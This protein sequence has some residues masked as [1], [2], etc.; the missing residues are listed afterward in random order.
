MIR[1]ALIHAVRAAMAPVEE[2]F[3][4]N[5]PEVR[6][7]NLLEDSLSADM[8]AA[9]ELTDG[10]SNRIVALARYSASTGAN[11]ILFTCSA[12]G[13]AIDKAATMLPMPVLKPNEAMFEQALDSGRRIGMLATFKPAVASMEQEFH[14]MVVH[15]DA[16]ATLETLVV[17][18][19]R[20]ALVAGDLELHDGLISEAASNLAHCDAIMLAH[21][22]MSTAEARVRA[23][24]RNKILTAPN[25][26]IFKLRALIAA[27][28]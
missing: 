11:G 2:A 6:R 23:K 5:W 13:S 26:A 10:L 19:A 17:P 4:A 16:K 20:E 8:E 25:S 9:G 18:G 15:N 24:V 14:E 22:S 21:F 1:I 27:G 3:Q 28:V 7:S 12:F